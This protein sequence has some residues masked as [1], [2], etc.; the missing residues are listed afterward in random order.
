[1]QN[2]TKTCIYIYMYTFVRVRTFKNRSKI[3][4]KLSKTRDGHKKRKKRLP[5]ATFSLRGRFF[6]IFGSRPGPKM[7]PKVVNSLKRVSTFS[8]HKRAL[9]PEACLEPFWD[10]SGRLPGWFWRP[11]GSLRGGF[12]MIFRCFFETVPGQR[13]CRKS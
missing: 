2:L 1:M 11:P 6:V 9:A 4:R 12:S 10:R 13:S 3:G 7:S 5:V 8:P